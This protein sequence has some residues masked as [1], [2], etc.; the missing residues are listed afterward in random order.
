VDGE[1]AILT[2]H[3]V[4]QHLRARDHWVKPDTANDDQAYLMVRVMETWFLA[5]VATLRAEFGKSFSEAKIPNWQNLEQVEKERIFT[6]LSECTGKQYA[7]GNRSFELLAKIN[8]AVV[9][10]RCPRARILL[11]RLRAL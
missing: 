1:D 3:S 11:D 5:D 8:P 7:K 9:E 10:Q 2:T 6:A 4:W